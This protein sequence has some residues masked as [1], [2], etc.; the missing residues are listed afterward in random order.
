MVVG[1][2]SGGRHKR[3]LSANGRCIRGAR[4][5]SARRSD[6]LVAVLSTF[7][8]LG[9]I[10][11]HCR[12]AARLGRRREAVVATVGDEAIRAGEVERLMAKATQGKK[13]EPDSL[14]FLQAQL[15]EEIIARRLVLAYA[16]RTGEAATA[17]EMAAERAALKSQ[18][19]ARRRSIEDFLKA[20][21]IGQAD[22]DRQLAWNVVWRK[23]WPAT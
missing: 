3:V 18:L 6:R 4:R 19:A 15:L 11:L 9:C 16:Q 17:A 13:P 21:S 7:A 20:E 23:Y 22:L 10:G 14:R 8:C 12:F 1:L 2:K 5:Q